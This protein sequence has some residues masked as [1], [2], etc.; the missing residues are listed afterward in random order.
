MYNN[1]MKKD[2][3]LVGG[4][5]SFRDRD[6]LLEYYKNKDIDQVW[7]DRFWHEWLMWSLESRFNFIKPSMP[8]K[9]NADYEVWKII[10][11]K[12]LN[13]VTSD[14]IVFVAHSLGTIFLMKYLVENGINKT[15]KQ[16]HLVASIVSNDFQPADDVEN[17]ATF[18]FDIKQ[19]SKLKDYCEQ[20]H[21]WHSKD[22]AMCTFKNAEFIKQEIPE[23][24]LHV[25]EDRG[26]FI[27]STFWELF[28]ELRT[29]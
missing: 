14:E 13:K 16:L 27:S 3:I 8:T 11:E 9:D 18:S 12:Y 20:I 1:A 5:L 17:T 29:Q 2:L 22:D 23:S 4:G 26:H 19:I 28:D 10:F 25:F 15:I 21:I 6:Q 7:G 24:L